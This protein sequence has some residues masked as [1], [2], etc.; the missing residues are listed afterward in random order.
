MRARSEEYS[1]PLF[2]NSPFYDI[3]NIAK[4]MSKSELANCCDALVDDRKHEIL[5][6]KECHR[7]KFF[8]ERLFLK[9][10]LLEI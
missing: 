4:I 2:L 6:F 1:F 5:K 9:L 8:K 7:F 10:V 3:A